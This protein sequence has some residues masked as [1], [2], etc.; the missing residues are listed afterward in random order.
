MPWAE[1]DA[2]I[3]PFLEPTPPIETQETT[4]AFIRQIELTDATG[5]LKDFYEALAEI[6]GGV[7][8]I[9]K[10]SSIKPAAIKA[11][12]DLYQS[13]L[14]HDSGLT[15]VEKEM[16]A[17]LVST[18]NGCA[19][20]VDHHGAALGELAGAASLPSRIGFTFRQAGLGERQTAILEFADK[21]TRDPAA[22]AESDVALLR[23]VALSDNEIVDL[24]QLVAY[25]NYTNR[26][27]TGL[28]V[29]PEAR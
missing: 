26:L 24:A 12:Q 5:E 20:C 27:A 8:N 25:F 21:L 14:Y 1:H 16:V 10:V 18:I 17:T 7:P 3:A 6:A 2:S 23:Q 11:A 9:V 22:M 15:M 29:D 4:M 28:G 19:Y 13:V